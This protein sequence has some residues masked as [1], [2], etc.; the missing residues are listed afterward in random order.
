VRRRRPA[1]FKAKKVVP[2]REIRTQSRA[3]VVKL[4]ESAAKICVVRS[5]GRIG[6]IL[7]LTPA[8]RALKERFRSS[9]LTLALGRDSRGGDSYRDVV[10]NAPFIDRFV[11][12]RFV[13]RRA[14]SMY[15]DVS[16]VCARYEGRGL[17]FINRIDIFARALGLKEVENKIPFYEVE[18]SESSTAER[19][20][21]SMGFGSRKIIG[22]HLR[23]LDPRRCW[24]VENY[25]ALAVEL[26]GLMDVLVFDEENGR[27]WTQTEK[28]KVL[29]PGSFRE[30]AALIDR[31]D[32]LVCPDSGPMHVAAAL[33]VPTLVLS[34]P[35]PPDSRINHYPTHRALQSDRR[36]RDCWYEECPDNL[37]M[38]DLGVKEVATEAIKLYAGPSGIRLRNRDRKRSLL[39]RSH[40]RPVDG[41][42]NSATQMVLALSRQLDRVFYQPTFIEPGWERLTP[43]GLSKLIAIEPPAAD[44]CVIYWP[45]TP[46]DPISLRCK[47]RYAF[48]MWETDRLPTSWFGVINQYDKLLVPCNGLVKVARDSGVRIPIEVVPL[49][50]D[51]KVWRYKEREKE[52]PFRF[53]FYAS[54]IGAGRKGGSL[55][56]DCFNE[57]FG[58]RKDV[59]LILKSTAAGGIDESKLG[60]NIRVIVERYT[61]EEMLRLLHGADCFL[62]PSRGEGFGLPPREAMAS[63][64]PVIAT[65]W[66]GM[67]SIMRLPFNYLLRSAQVTCDWFAQI[68]SYLLQNGSRDFGHWAEPDVEDLKRLM[69]HAVDHP[70]EVHEYGR[71]CSDWIRHHE[72][73]DLTAQKLIGAL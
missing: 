36:C 52:R 40:L 10:R 18:E 67:E 21:S 59:E 57:L 6:D 11:D 38:K 16:S 53:I 69:Q 15:V 32:L 68:P 50:I 8:L 55:V 27:G 42:G 48:T 1:L 17:P 22:L 51:P 56:V 12:A 70:D 44:Y 30:L 7:M 54:A 20:V 13:D 72:T 29:N 3:P 25:K 28:I 24:P 34:G 31:C 26:S 5:N 37:C 4:P 46:P 64:M 63:G 60:P 39:F 33:G 41:Y 66:L 61:A 43:P 2:Q 19:V 71:M 45:P 65:D 47:R 14:Y 35:I 49:G 58:G 23:S 62:F 9:E 73:W